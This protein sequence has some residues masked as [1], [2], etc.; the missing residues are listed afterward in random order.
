ML[1]SWNCM[2]TN[3]QIL[4]KN[5]NHWLV[6]AFVINLSLIIIRLFSECL[7][8]FVKKMKYW[9]VYWLVLCSQRLIMIINCLFNWQKAKY[10]VDTKLLVSVFSKKTNE[11]PYLLFW[12]ERAVI[13][14]QKLFLFSTEDSDS[15]YCCWW[16]LYFAFIQIGQCSVWTGSEIW[17][18]GRWHWKGPKARIQTLVAQ[19]ITTLCVRSLP[20][21]LVLRFESRK[22]YV[23][24]KRKIL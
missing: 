17:E 12:A 5:A 1:N 8:C 22:N 9:S 23:F 19:N 24:C 11:L 2:L 4:W 14:K 18:W 3:D 20:M 21:K 6:H 13:Y 7:T 15:L 16:D 10:K